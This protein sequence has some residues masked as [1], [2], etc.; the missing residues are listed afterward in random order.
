MEYL[1][2]LES[3]AAGARKEERERAGGEWEVISREKGLCSHCRDGVE[4]EGQWGVCRHLPVCSTYEAWRYS[5]QK[6]LRKYPYYFSRLLESDL[7]D[8]YKR[9]TC[10]PV[11]S[12]TGS[13]RAIKTASLFRKEALLKFLQPNPE[14]YMLFCFCYNPCLNPSVSSKH[15]TCC[16]YFCTFEIAISPSRSHSHPKL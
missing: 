9:L 10:A 3:V 4:R 5:C 15:R 12:Q 7:W 1:G 6:T 2:K 16:C 13:R 14:H 11:T 8:V